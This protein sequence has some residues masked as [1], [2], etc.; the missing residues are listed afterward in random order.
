MMF[1]NRLLIS[2]IGIINIIEHQVTQVAFKNCAL[3]NK[4]ITKN[5]ETTIDNAEDLHLFMRM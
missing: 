2:L 1:I 5:D 4:Y 3:F